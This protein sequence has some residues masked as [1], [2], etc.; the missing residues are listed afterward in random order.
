M[1]G[2]LLVE[3]YKAIKALATRRNTLSKTWGC[4]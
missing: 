1:L 4:I 2:D 3:P